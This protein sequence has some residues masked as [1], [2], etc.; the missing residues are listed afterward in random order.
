M[1][2]D[3]LDEFLKYKQR[4]DELSN[5]KEKL[6]KAV[7]DAAIVNS[8]YQKYLLANPNKEKRKRLNAHVSALREEILKLIPNI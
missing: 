4:M 6:N 8:A 1:K 7:K 2:K 5:L 3:P